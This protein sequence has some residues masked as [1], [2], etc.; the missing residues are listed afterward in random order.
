MHST[1]DSAVREV[2][3]GPRPQAVTLGVARPIACRGAARAT[4]TSAARRPSPSLTTQPV[5]AAQSTRLGR[6]LLNA[7]SRAAADEGC[8][9]VDQRMLEI[10]GSKQAL[11]DAYVRDSVVTAAAPGAVDLSEVQLARLIVEQEQKRLAMEAM[12]QNA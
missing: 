12:G 11:F 4:S 7:I 9:A 3:G 6:F 2:T 8:P 10:L 1:C 5:G